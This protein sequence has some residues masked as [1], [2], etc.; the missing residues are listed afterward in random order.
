M[1]VF[2]RL[3]FYRSLMCFVFL[4]FT[5]PGVQ[6]VTVLTLP[7]S[8]EPPGII[9]TFPDT[10]EFSWIKQRFPTSTG[11]FSWNFGGGTDGGMIFD[12][13]QAFGEMTD[14]F[15]MFNQ[16]AG[17]YSVNDG[18]SID[19]DNT[20]DMSNLRMRQANNIIDVGS[21]SGY[22]TLVPYFVDFS[23]RADNQNGWSID[24]NGMYHLFYNTRG[25]CIDCELTI[26]MYGSV[27]PV[28]AA[29]WLFASGLLG[30]ASFARRRYMA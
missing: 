11:Y 8:F 12:Q 10:S 25:T 29:I 9:G 17:F 4:Y 14:V 20:I 7:G 23:L 30:L 5:V 6:A 27:V 16:R 18:L 1:V 21:G 26:H 22:E 13:S 24:V 28:P 19:P 2:T 15:I 3:C